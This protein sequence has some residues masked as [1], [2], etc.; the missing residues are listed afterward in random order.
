M[1]RRFSGPS[2][3]PPRSTVRMRSSVRVMPA[4]V[5]LEGS[6]GSEATASRLRASSSAASCPADAGV[7]ESVRTTAYVSCLELGIIQ[8]SDVDLSLARPDPALIDMHAGSIVEPR[9]GPV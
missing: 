2:T 1:T 3:S 5:T 6:P 8:T 9:P 4:A 7:H